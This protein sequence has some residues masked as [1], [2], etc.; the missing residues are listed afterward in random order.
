MLEPPD[1]RISKLGPATVESPLVCNF[2]DTSGFFVE[3]D[4][5]T[6][7]DTT[8]HAW[9]HGT[10]PV[11]LEA[12]NLEIAGP[13]QLIFFRPEAVKAAIVTCGGVCPGL[14]NVIRSLVLCLWQQY[15]VRHI[16]GIRYGYAGLVEDGPAPMMLNPDTVDGIQMHGGTILGTS[17][18]PQSPEAMLDFLRARGVQMLFTIGG[19]G[20]QRGA[21]QLAQAALNAKYQ[22]AVVGL[23]KTID[24]DLDYVDRSFGFET[25]FSLADQALRA[26]YAEARAVRNGVGIVKLMGRHSGYITALS[27]LAHSQVNFVLVPEVRFEFGGEHGFLRSLMDRLQSYSYALIAVAEGAGQ[28][29]LPEEVQRAG[30][31]ASGNPKLADFG[32]ALRREIEKH[33]KENGVTVNVRYI[34]PSYMIRSAVATPNDSVFCLQLAQHAVHAAMSG[35]TAMMVGIWKGTFTHVPLATAIH[36]KKLIDP[37]GPIWLSVLQATNQPAVMYRPYVPGGL[38]NEEVSTET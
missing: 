34:D 12:I 13:R 17:R 16:R 32:L 38:C 28:D 11:E 5:R 22:L 9:S 36:R 4:D 26:A 8:G 37:K 19:D 24:N 23:P 20:T 18:G 3:D 35:R 10:L 29:L 2:S 25:A 30:K 1:F 6:L 14:N 15:G 33:G 31:D 21:L 27:S 7:L